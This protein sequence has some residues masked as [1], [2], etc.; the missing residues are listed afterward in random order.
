[1]EI[2]P[3]RTPEPGSFGGRRFRSIVWITGALWALLI[4]WPILLGKVPLPADV[5]LNS[6]AWQDLAR[7]PHFQVQHAEM[8]DAITLGYPW[9][10]QRRERLLAGD[11]PL[12]NERALMGSPFLASSQPGVFNPVALA[13]MPLPP[14]V[15]WSLLIAVKAWLAFTFT[16]FAA[17]RLGARPFGSLAAGMTFSACGFMTAWSLWPITDTALWL[18][19]IFWAVS[20]LSQKLDVRS[21]LTAGII[22][23]LP[24][25]AG[26]AEIAAFVTLAGAL[27]AAFLTF[28]EPVDVG[29]R[30]WRLPALFAISAVI[31]VGLASV[32]LLPTLEWIGSLSRSSETPLRLALPFDDVAGIVSR[33]STSNPNSLGVSIPEGASYAGI[34]ALLLAP[35]ALLV[36]RRLATFLIVLGGCSAAVS[37]S[38][39]PFFD[40]YQL[41]PLLRA[42]PAN[43]L[44]LVTD[45]CLALLL[46]LSLTTLEG[47]HLRALE[48]KRAR[49]F[50]AAS[51][52]AIG[53]FTVAVL[54]RSTPAR[55]G[56]G[57]F[58][59]GLGVT[60]VLLI[61]FALLARLALAALDDRL[62]QR[63]VAPLVALIALDLATFASGHLP[64]F[65]SEE[66]FPTPRVLGAIAPDLASRYRVASVNGVM[67]VNSM[68]FFG[69]RDPVGY[70]YPLRSTERLLRPLTEGRI[71]PVFVDSLSSQA[72][73]KGGGTRL[74]LMNTRFFVASGLNGSTQNLELAKPEFRLVADFG[75]LQLFEFPAALPRAWF[76]AASGQRVVESMR[77]ALAALDDPGFN[78]ASEAV[79]IGGKR[80]ARDDHPRRIDVGTQV[81]EMPA[82][83]EV[84]IQSNGDGRV[85]TVSAETAGLVVISEAYDR[86]WKATVDGKRAPVLRVDVA[87]MAVPV[88]PGTHTIRLSYRPRSFVVGSSVS[89]ATLLVVAILFAADSRWRVPAA[90]FSRPGPEGALVADEP[91]GAQLRRE[92]SQLVDCTAAGG[93]RRRSIEDDGS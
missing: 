76:V 90:A 21:C 12:W 70:D 22:L 89:L 78:P 66:V 55:H 63:R 87:L 52:S 5:L 28:N 10:V 65:D 33:D 35:L 92:G 26:H 68:Q 43:R 23:A 69:F 82:L 77:D 30:R 18:P 60:L 84:S 44:L 79:L 42:A 13:L 8:G 48:A 93:A 39:P 86:G 50:L 56:A 80:R 59:G 85:A 32:Q 91:P 88:D 7:Q 72:L 17:R 57:G 51:L 41:I 11:I 73:A 54:L 81:K 38:L 24:V 71:A 9:Y 67:P 4:H 27:L 58:R 45:F 3:T 74:R 75:M 15:G 31:A 6:I 16:A 37:L 25:L 53:L 64:Y 40:T 47:P 61:C 46:A 62:R 83:V 49:F 1:M 20:A 2:A 19:A 29:S 14:H 36:Q 34:A